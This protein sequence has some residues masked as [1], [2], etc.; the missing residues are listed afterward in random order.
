MGRKGWKKIMPEYGCKE[1]T[2]FTITME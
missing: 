2:L 1:K